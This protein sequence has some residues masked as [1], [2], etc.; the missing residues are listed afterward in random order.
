MIIERIYISP[1]HNYFGHHGQPSGRAPAL[2]V[3]EVECV[4]GAGLRGDRFFSYK[5]DYKGQ[6]TFFAMETYEMLCQQLQ[7][8]DK[9]PSVFRRNI[10]TRGADL[11][12]LIGQ[13][14]EVQGIRFLG[15]QESS[16]CYWMDEA[17]APGAEAALKGLGGLRAKVLSGGILRTTQQLQQ[18]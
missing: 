15:T 9:D 11:R 12:L 17:F 16:P 5:E 3:A 4:A 14:F 7:V 1:E 13:E 6:V 2:S 10:V 18:S 8:T